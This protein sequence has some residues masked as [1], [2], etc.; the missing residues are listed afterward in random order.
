[1]SDFKS[2]QIKTV[3]KDLL[4]KK[5]LTYEDVA[6]ELECSVPTVKRILGPEEL[7]LPRLLHLCELVDINL[8]DLE[9]LTQLNK[10]SHDKF[11]PTQEEFLANNPHFLAYYM[12]LF[13]MT[14]E[15]IAEKYKLNERASQKYLLQLEKQELIR[16]TGKLKVKTVFKELPGFGDGPLAKKHA[17]SFINNANKF[18]LKVME[19]KLFSQN[20]KRDEGAPA[21]FAIKA[22]KCT[23]SAYANFVKEQEK[24]RDAFFKLADYEEKSLPA[25][26]LKTATVINAFAMVENDEPALSILDDF[27]GVIKNI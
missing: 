25:S 1:M 18:F 13:S 11:T 3:I 22:I 16:V 2:T 4:K 6:S 14:P 26:E 10:G 27:F 15:E 20:R 19:D 7:S 17:E 8:A 23:K 12:Q 5:K 24:S 21:G 9:T